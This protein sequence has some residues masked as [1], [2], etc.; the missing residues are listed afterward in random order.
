MS[1]F[2]E[3]KMNSTP[4]GLLLIINNHDF[5]GNFENREGTDIDCEGLRNLFMDLGFGVEVRANLTALV[6]CN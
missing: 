1:F 4:R 5:R 3:Y 6:I 2:Q